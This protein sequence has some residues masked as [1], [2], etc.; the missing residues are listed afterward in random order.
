METRAAFHRCNEFGDVVEDAWLDT[1]D[2]GGHFTAPIMGD[3]E[4]LMEVSLLEQSFEPFLNLQTLNANFGA[5]PQGSGVLAVSPGGDIYFDEG[6]SIY[7]TAGRNLTSGVAGGVT[8]FTVDSQANLY[9]IVVDGSAAPKVAEV[10]VIQ[11][12]FGSPVTVFKSGNAAMTFSSIAVSGPFALDSS[13]TSCSTAQPLTATSSCTI[14]VKFSPTA[15]GPATGSLTVAVA[16]L[17]TPQFVLTG[18]GAPVSTTTAVAASATSLTANNPLTLT[19]TVSPE[20]GSTPQGA[21]TFQSGSTNLGSSNLNSAGV[22][23]LTIK[24]AWGSYSI[25]ATYG[26]SATDLTSTSS[27]IAITVTP[28][29]ATATTLAITPNPASYQQTV[30]FAVNVTGS[31]SAPTGSVAIA[32]G[33]TTLAIESLASGAATYSNGSLAPGQHPITASYSGDANNQTSTSAP[34]SLTIAPFTMQVA[35]PS[36][37]TIAPGASVSANVS[38]ASVNNYAGAITLACSVGY[39]GS[40]SPADSP[41]CSVSPASVPLTAGGSAA[42]SLTVTTTATWSRSRPRPARSPQLNP[43]PLPCNSRGRRNV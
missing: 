14:G 37:T 20:S 7:D 38:I 32:D 2:T 3:G 31:G 6:S 40:G 19:A 1:V 15:T 8:A 42:A 16:G 33:S 17:V 9:A 18:T 26:G 10:P 13:K 36:S 35:P 25:S 5:L 4:N 23:S 24:P 11:Q 41:S 34:V 28:P 30:N 12:P 39:Q 21:V 43:S 29:A 27:A 22:A